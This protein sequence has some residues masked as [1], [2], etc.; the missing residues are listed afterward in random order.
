VWVTAVAG[1]AVAAFRFSTERVAAAFAVVAFGSMGY[2]FLFAQPD[3]ESYRT[4]RPFLS[5]V[6]E[7]LGSELT[8]LVLYKTRA[9]VFYLAPPRSLAEAATSAE[10]RGLVDRGSVRWVLAHERDLPDVEFAA[11][12]VSRQPVHPW[13]EPGVEVHNLVL[14]EVRR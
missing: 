4:E 5:E 6:R 8:G 1:V 9:T 3:V 2:L 14:L 13:E 7:R 11:R 12:V 10:L